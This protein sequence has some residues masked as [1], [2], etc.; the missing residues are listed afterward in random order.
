[1]LEGAR[2]AT[3]TRKHRLAAT[4][5]LLGIMKWC[6]G[7]QASVALSK[8]EMLC[9]VGIKEKGSIYQTVNIGDGKFDVIPRDSRKG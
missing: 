2:F 6:Q 9:S 1:M 8:C 3:Q 4:G 5:N 7:V